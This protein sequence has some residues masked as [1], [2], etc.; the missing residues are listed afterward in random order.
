MEAVSP[1]CPSRALAQRS[2]R[3][4]TLCA[5]S[6]ELAPRQHVEAAYH[7]G[8]S[9]MLKHHVVAAFLLCLENAS[10]R[11]TPPGHRKWCCAWTSNQKNVQMRAH[12]LAT[13]HASQ[14]R[15]SFR[16]RPTEQGP[17]G[18]DTRGASLQKHTPFSD[19]TTKTILQF[20]RPKYVTRSISRQC[21]HQAPSTLPLEFLWATRANNVS[22]RAPHHDRWKP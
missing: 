16:E 1:Q 21:L 5:L 7:D 15:R 13:E 9:S 12:A 3:T 10:C 20:R 4:R 2:A 19:N 14:C 8:T 6:N 18:S 17:S 11:A 22:H